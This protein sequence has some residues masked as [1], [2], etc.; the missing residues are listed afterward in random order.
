MGFNPSRW[1]IALVLG[2]GAGVLPV[3]G[4][5]DTGPVPLDPP[6]CV[7]LLPAVTTSCPQPSPSQPQ[8]GSVSST[9]STQSSQARAFRRFGDP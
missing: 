6:A 5:A 7:S 9:Q 4:S 2:L 1:F 8:A 3:A